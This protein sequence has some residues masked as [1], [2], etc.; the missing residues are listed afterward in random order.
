[1]FLLSETYSRGHDRVVDIGFTVGADM[2]GEPIGV[3]AFL[4]ASPNVGDRLSA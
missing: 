2:K 1:M 4:D 3:K